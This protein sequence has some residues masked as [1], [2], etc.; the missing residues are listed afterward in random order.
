RDPR[1]GRPTRLTISDPQYLSQ[2]LIDGKLYYSIPNGAMDASPC[3]PIDEAITGQPVL[4]LAVELML[5]ITDGGMRQ[6]GV[7]RADLGRGGAGAVHRAA[8]P[9]RANTAA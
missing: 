6:A 8:G 4:A 7:E 2:P 1:S 9:G 5:R 3:S